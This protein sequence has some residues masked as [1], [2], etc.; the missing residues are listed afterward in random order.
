M[1]EAEADKI[2]EEITKCWYKSRKNEDKK[3]LPYQRT[4]DLVI[5]EIVHAFKDIMIE[6]I[7]KRYSNTK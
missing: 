5:I 1:N 6:F 3:W 4:A 7:N 2:Y